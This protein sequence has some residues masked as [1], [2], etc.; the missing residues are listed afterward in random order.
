MARSRNARRWSP[1]PEPAA[2][3]TAVQNC[4]DG[5]GESGQNGFAPSALSAARVSMLLII[6]ALVVVTTLV[7]IFHV[8]RARDAASLGWMSE[9]W[10]AEHRA[11]HAS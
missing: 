9:R 5:D 11:M 4:T 2:K 3:L 6:G 7:S 1:S 10:L 8:L